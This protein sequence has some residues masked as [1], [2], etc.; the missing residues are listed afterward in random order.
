MAVRLM[1]LLIAMALSVDIGGA[2]LSEGF[3]DN[4]VWLILYA[5]M[6]DLWKST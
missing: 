6:L 2:E 3:Y 5:V 1:L 4:L